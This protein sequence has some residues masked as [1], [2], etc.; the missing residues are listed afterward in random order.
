MA[1]FLS[2]TVLSQLTELLFLITLPLAVQVRLG[3]VA[4]VVA[5]IW[6]LSLEAQQGQMVEMVEMV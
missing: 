2:T 4:R 3:M 5:R 6:L 1:H